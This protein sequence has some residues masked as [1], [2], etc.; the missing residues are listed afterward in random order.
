MINSLPKVSIITTFYNEEELLS[1]CLQSIKNQFYKNIELI[2]VNDGSTDQSIIIAESFKN[3]LQNCKII[4][5]KNSGHSQARNIGLQNATGEFVTFLDADDEFETDAISIFVNKILLDNSDLVISRFTVYN[6][7]NLSEMIGGWKQR[8]QKTTKT[9]LLLN[10]MF[11]HGISEN[12]WAKLFRT[13]L[14]K[15]IFFE[16][17]LWF[18]DRPFLFEYLFLS[19]KVSFTERSLIKIHKRNSSITR[20]I[21]EPKR[22]I[23]ANIVFDLELKIAAKYDAKVSLKEKIAKHYLSV[24]VD[25]YLIQIID[26][27]NIVDLKLVRITLLKQVAQFKNKLKKEQINLAKKDILVCKLLQFPLFFGWNFLNKTLRL[28]KKQRIQGILKLK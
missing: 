27:K 19:K 9:K 14:A 3:T 16:K 20:R 12:V 11:N 23:D 26:K 21:I 17:G 24:L 13:Q 25:N 8:N 18:D 6:Q 7:F 2:L 10:E 15:Q 5:I 1:R 4:S 28:I 22:I